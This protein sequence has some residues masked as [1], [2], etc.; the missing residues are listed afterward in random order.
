[1]NTIFTKATFTAAITTAIVL[2][3]GVLLGLLISLGSIMTGVEP[4]GF[5]GQVL[6]V[7]Y[8]VSFWPIIFL[9]RISNPFGGVPNFALIVGIVVTAEFVG[10]FI[11]SVIVLFIWSVLK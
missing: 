5:L 3:I 6:Q 7:V 10:Y 9:G 4:T 2:I 1:M 11:L 8:L